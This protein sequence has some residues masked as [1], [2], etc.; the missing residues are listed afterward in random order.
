MS[1]PSTPWFRRWGP[2]LLVLAV[3]VASGWRATHSRKVGGDFLRYHRAG[4]LVSTGRAD[5]IYSVELLHAQSVYAEERA[6]DRAERG[7]RGDPLVEREFKYL[8]A[9]AVLLAPLGSLHPRDAWV[10]WSGWNGLMVGLTFLAAW[11]VAAQVT[12][13]RWFLV[14]AL[15]L[16][17]T[18]NDN[19]LLGQLNPT[20]IAAAT[21]AVWAVTRGKDAAA[22]LLA[23]FGG[24]VKFY[25]WAL[26]IWFLW[27]RRFAAAGMVVLGIAVFAW[28]VPATVLGPARATALTQEYFDVRAHHYTGAAPSD[29]PGH[30]VKSFVYRTLG[31]VPY[32]TGPETDHVVRDVSV[33]RLD[34]VVLKWLVVGLCGVLLWLVLTPAWGPLRAALDPRGPPEAGL[35]FCWI[36]LASPEARGPHFLYLAL[37]VSALVVGTVH[38]W[39]EQLPGHRAALALAATGAALLQAD[40]GRIVGDALKET[41]AAYCGLGIAT[42]AILVALLFVHR[43]EK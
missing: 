12:K 14:V 29:V 11:R 37:P 36:L 15:V 25:P 41:F 27:K 2:W 42:G 16:L 32:Q 40:S 31:G 43:P 39:R 8:P 10:V 21:T 28:A 9:T 23:A 1:S 17:H 6:A 4:R 13:A 19:L 38:A 26:A 24:T 7:E 18:A 22:G 34:P 5:E 35:F 30:S 20:A 33:A 3:A